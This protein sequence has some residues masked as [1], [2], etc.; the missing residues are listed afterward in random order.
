MKS[1]TAGIDLKTTSVFISAEGHL[2]RVSGNWTGSPFIHHNVGSYAESRTPSV[3]G[4]QKLLQKVCEGNTPALQK[5]G[6]LVQDE[7]EECLIPEFAFPTCMCLRTKRSP[8]P[9]GRSLKR[10][11]QT[12][13]NHFVSK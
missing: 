3:S 9:F 8:C 6:K 10:T 5:V 11:L 13:G 7:E 12:L 1:S 4:P 2:L